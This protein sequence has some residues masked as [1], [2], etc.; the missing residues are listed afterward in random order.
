MFFQNGNFYIRLNEKHIL[1]IPDEDS[2]MY[3]TLLETEFIDSYIRFFKEKF[4]AL[5][6]LYMSMEGNIVLYN[7]ILTPDGINYFAKLVEK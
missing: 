6:M 3:H 5:P 4:N 2:K 1:R 7:R